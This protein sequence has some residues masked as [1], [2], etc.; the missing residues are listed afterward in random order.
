MEAS[1]AIHLSHY[2]SN[3]PSICLSFREFLPR[4]LIENHCS[5]V[6]FI[7]KEELLSQ[8]SVTDIQ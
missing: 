4:Q 7:K 2:I 1:G 5:K 8:L 3:L 6:S